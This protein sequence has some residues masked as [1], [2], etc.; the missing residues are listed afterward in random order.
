MHVYG[1][2]R[3]GVFMGLTLQSAGTINSAACEHAGARL[4]A[5]HTI[6]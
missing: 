2:R 3:T 5:N 6:P 1:E 4:S